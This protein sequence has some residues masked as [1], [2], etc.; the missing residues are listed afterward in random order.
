MRFE[1]NAQAHVEGVLGKHAAMGM[2][3]ALRFSRGARGVH[4]HHGSFRIHDVGLFK[5][6][7]MRTGPRHITLV[8]CKVLSAAIHN[9]DGMNT[10]DFA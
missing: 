1:I 10:W 8:R 6:N 3:G 4:Q 5:G 9:D 7:L 2:H